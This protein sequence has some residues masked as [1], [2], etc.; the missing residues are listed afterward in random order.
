MHT[1][2]STLKLCMGGMGNDLW[3]LKYHFADHYIPLDWNVSLSCYILFNTFQEEPVISEMENVST[4]RIQ[5]A[6]LL[7]S[8]EKL[9]V[10]PVFIR[11]IHSYTESEDTDGSSV[12]LSGNWNQ[13]HSEQV[14]GEVLATSVPHYKYGKERFA[15][16]D[17]KYKAGCKADV[18]NVRFENETRLTVVHDDSTQTRGN[19]AYQ[20]DQ[21]DEKGGVC[22]TS[23]GRAENTNKRE[24][25]QEEQPTSNMQHGQTSS[26]NKSKCNGFVANGHAKLQVTADTLGGGG[27]RQCYSPRTVMTK[28]SKEERLE[29][30]HHLPSIKD[31]R[32]ILQKRI[33]G[34]C[35]E[36]KN[37]DL[38]SP[39]RHASAFVI[40]NC[41]TS[42][43]AEPA[44]SVD[45]KTS[46]S[47]SSIPLQLE[48]T[49]KTPG[50]NDQALTPGSPKRLYR[51]HVYKNNNSE[52]SPSPRQ[53]PPVPIRQDVPRTNSTDEEVDPDMPPPPPLS[54]HPEVLAASRLKRDW[55]EEISKSEEFD[56]EQDDVFD[57]QDS[58][59]PV[60]Y[61]RS[62]FCESLP[63]FSTK[64]L[65]GM[66]TFL[67]SPNQ[68]ID[69]S[70]RGRSTNTRR[71]SGPMNTRRGSITTKKRWSFFWRK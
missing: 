23:E 69:Q 42:V 63:A 61:E 20:R 65:R 30:L 57:T 66:D 8:P 11:N 60:S 5:M 10:S 28:K 13:T 22:V 14:S 56:E 1:E 49:E 71:G 34:G 47:L 37:G 50:G 4:I 59:T 54:T 12:P 9:Q 53:K 64:A 70:I 7:A 43:Q 18:K 2:L 17:T 44:S 25:P 26:A 36:D 67:S 24:C 39:S 51:S 40:E 3:V 6:P 55:L 46:S 27:I 68:T 45:V 31:K 33:Q 62:L 35:E 21:E 15:E 32:H 58:A 29:E 19:V 48:K 41:L 16:P 52:A 38:E